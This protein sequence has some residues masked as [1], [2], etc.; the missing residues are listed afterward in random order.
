MIDLRR[1][2]KSNTC[3]IC[4]KKK[5]FLSARKLCSN[6]SKNKNLSAIYQMRA[7]EGPVYEKWKLKI[8]NALE[9]L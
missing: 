5:K 3:K 4:G 8:I 2:R 1:K 9:K 7:K 6:C